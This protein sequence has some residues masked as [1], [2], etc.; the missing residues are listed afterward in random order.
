MHDFFASKGIIHQTTCVE[1]PEINGIL[2][3]KHQHLLN[4]TRALLFKS[5][6]PAIFW[7]FVVQH[8]TFL[9]NCVSTLLLNN[10][11]VYERLYKK[12]YVAFL[13]FLFLDVY[14][15]LP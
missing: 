10:A 1:I 5:H 8:A 11:T 12:K 2:E 4:I 13:I 3:R 9:I 6:L 14:V 7:C 15:I